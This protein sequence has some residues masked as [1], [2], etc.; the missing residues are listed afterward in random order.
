M[1]PIY[2]AALS[3]FLLSAFGYVIYQFWIRPV[4]KYRWLKKNAS[5]NIV[6]YLDT[7]NGDYEADEAMA[8]NDAAENKIK[9][10]RKLSGDLNDCFNEELPQWYKLLLQRREESP[11]DASKHMMVL[12]NTRDYSHA[13]NRAEKISRLLFP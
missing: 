4:L 11:V 9:I 8:D 5:V 12:S 2:I 6:S 13:R 1:E 10:V 3:C 7:I